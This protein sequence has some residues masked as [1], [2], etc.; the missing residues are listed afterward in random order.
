MIRL[1]L[2]QINSLMS[3]CFG[4]PYTFC[5]LYTLK[6]IKWLENQMPISRK[7]SVTKYFG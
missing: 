3:I 4:S 1:C 5:S 7:V 6:L 2:I